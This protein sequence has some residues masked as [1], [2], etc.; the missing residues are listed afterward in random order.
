M[1]GY[2]ISKEIDADDSR[3]K[4]WK[5]QREEKG[6]DNTELWNL[7]TTIAKFLADRL[8]AFKE[9]T[10]TH[11]FELTSEEWKDTLQEMI[12]CFEYYTNEENHD[13]PEDD[14]MAQKKMK[15]GLELLNEYI[16]TLWD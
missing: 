1:I 3:Q 9:Y 2:S 6:F 14:R 7:D 10:V 5:R 13:T 11:P 15:R 4:V 12:D 16:F 8:K